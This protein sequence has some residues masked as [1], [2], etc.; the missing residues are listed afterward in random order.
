MIHI[1]QKKETDELGSESG[2]DGTFGTVL[3]GF[4]RGVGLTLGVMFS[5]DSYSR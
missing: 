5:A 3:G 1:N 4:L 2:S